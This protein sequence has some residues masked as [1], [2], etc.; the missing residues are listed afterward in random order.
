M[1][2]IDVD[3]GRIVR[4]IGVVGA[5]TFDAVALQFRTQVLEVLLDAVA[6]AQRGVAQGCLRFRFGA[7][8]EHFKAIQGAGQR[9]VEQGIA[10]VGLEPDG[11]CCPQGARHKVDW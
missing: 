10:L 5:E 6:Q 2:D 3:R 7:G 1:I 8:R 11:M 4:Q 9:A